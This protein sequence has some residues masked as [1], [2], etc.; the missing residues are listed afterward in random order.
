[1]KTQTRIN[2]WWAALTVWGVVNLV[3]LLQSAGFS[4]RVV[5]GSQEIN[6][7]LG[8]ALFG[9]G[10]PAIL[11]VAA[12]VRAQSGWRQWIGAVVYIVFIGLMAVVDTCGRWSFARQCA[13][14]FW[15]RTWCC[16]LAQ[17]S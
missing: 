5:T 8:Y 13:M 2:P 3:N 11:A 7:L 4:S 17:S 15:S 14:K 16:S 12:F 1:M 6:H 9:L 10:I